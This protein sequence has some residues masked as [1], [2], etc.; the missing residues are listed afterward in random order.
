MNQLE[1]YIIKLINVLECITKY[2]DANFLHLN[3]TKS[4]FI[5]FKTPRAQGITLKFLL[6]N[7]P[8]KLVETIRFLGVHIDE[9]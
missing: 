9:N 6:D 5:H 8:L 7:K 2:V 4:K 1:M 3:I